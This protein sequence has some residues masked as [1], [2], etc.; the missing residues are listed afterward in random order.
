MKILQ[1]FAF[2]RLPIKNDETKPE[3]W[4]TGH[5]ELIIKIARARE[6]D[7]VY[8][9]YFI[10]IYLPTLFYPILLGRMSSATDDHIKEPIKEINAAGIG[11]TESQSQSQPLP[12]ETH[13]KGIAEVTIEEK[14]AVK[15]LKERLLKAEITY[16]LTDT[17]VLRFFRGRKRNIEKTYSE[18]VRYIKWRIENKADE[19][20][21]DSIKNMINNKINLLTG[22]DANGR[23]ILYCISRNHHADQRDIEEMKRYIIYYLDKVI[24][25][26]IAE[27][28]QAILVFDLGGY[29]Y[30]NMDIEG[31]KILIDILQS[32]YPELLYICYD[33]SAP[34]IFWGFWMIIKHFIDPDTAKKIHF[35]N[36]EDLIKYIDIKLI[37]DEVLHFKG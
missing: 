18:L 30:R 27:E 31:S 22:P 16:E 1:L 19:I 24:K 23:P 7:R 33:V 9:S 14:D 26:G 6:L 4:K 5:T 15:L 29:S 10:L 13:D 11:L 3:T 34:F 8:L 28:E 12:I 20:T 21:E 35:I 32:N 36:R 2:T 17:C 25:M 37:P